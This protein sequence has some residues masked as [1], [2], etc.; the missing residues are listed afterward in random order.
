M[1]GLDEFGDFLSCVDIMLGFML[2]EA[3]LNRPYSIALSN[4][5]HDNVPGHT[6]SI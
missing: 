6:S 1:L 4:V 3:C 2:R 5:E